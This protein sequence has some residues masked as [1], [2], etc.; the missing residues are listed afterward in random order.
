[1]DGVYPT[2]YCP[3]QICSGGT[4][5]SSSFIRNHSRPNSA[6]EIFDK[7][8]PDYLTNNPPPSL[9]YVRVAPSRQNPSKMVYWIN[10][11]ERPR[12]IL[13]KNKKYQLNVSTHGYPFYFTTDPTGGHGNK[14]NITQVPPSDYY[15]ST[16]TIGDST[17]FYY[18]SSAHPDMGGEVIVKII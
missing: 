3:K 1:M 9:L 10:G 6:T 2:S 12:L 7:G 18:Q 5:V 17:N 4:I 16:Y 11:W 8:W 13:T 14:D 15:V